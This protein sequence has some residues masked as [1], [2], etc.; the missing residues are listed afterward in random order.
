[1]LFSFL[2]TNENIPQ[3]LAQW[4]VDS[5]LGPVGFLAVVNI[6][7]LLAGNIMEP[8]SIILIT[9]PILFPV[10]MALGIDPI[11]FGIMITV[12]MEIGMITPPVGL[13][14]YVASGISRLGMTETTIATFPWLLTMLAFLML[15]TYW[16]AL[17]LWLPRTMGMV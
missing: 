2:L 12:N 16:P 4:L 13:N 11:H 8:S 3:A 15:I 5:G 10:A 6:L 17:S 9:A 7:L 14:L 1:V